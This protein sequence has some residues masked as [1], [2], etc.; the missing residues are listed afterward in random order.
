MFTQIRN[1]C[2][3][4]YTSKGDRK[5]QEPAGACSGWYL[6]HSSQGRMFITQILGIRLFR[7]GMDVLGVDGVGGCWRES[8]ITK[9]GT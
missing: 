1:L 5:H 7:E 4:H 2:W 6:E 8:I 9:G 3:L